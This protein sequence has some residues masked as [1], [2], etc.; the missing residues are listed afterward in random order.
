[1]SPNDVA[2]GMLGRLCVAG[3]P[4]SALAEGATEELNRTNARD[5]DTARACLAN[6]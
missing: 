5:R 2:I 1:M 4:V 3:C 6:I